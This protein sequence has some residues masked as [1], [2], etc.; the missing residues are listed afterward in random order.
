VPA[1]ARVFVDGQLAHGRTPMTVTITQDDFHELRFDL[2]GYES[3]VRALKPE[4][5]DASVTVHLGAAKID[6]GTLW[7]DGPLGTDVWMDGAPTGAA[8]PTLGLQAPT[9]IH[10]IELR[11]S[12]GTVIASK[13]IRVARG[14]ILH[15]APLAK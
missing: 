7:I 5:T 11:S 14:Q 4:D 2:D 6:R 12:D 15:V 13:A 3:E 10:T 1:G 8:T 9:G